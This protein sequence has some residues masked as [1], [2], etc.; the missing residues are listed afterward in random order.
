M[1]ASYQEARFRAK[2]RSA[3]HAHGL[4]L[5]E[6]AKWEHG[7]GGY[8]GSFAECDGV[9]VMDRR[10]PTARSASSY[11]NEAA[12]KYEPALIVQL[13]TAPGEE[14]EWLMGAWCLE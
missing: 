9:T 5:I 14:A 10:F 6:Q 3:A 4:A 11:L 12:E 8:T 13:E 2:D 1:G 7:H